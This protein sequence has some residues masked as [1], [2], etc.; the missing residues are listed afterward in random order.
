LSLK[1]IHGSDT[2]TQWKGIPQSV[3]LCILRGNDDY[4]VA[5]VPQELPVRYIR[6]GRLAEEMMYAR[7]DGTIAKLRSKLS[8]L[9][10]L[11]I[12]YLALSPMS[13][14][15]LHDLF[16]VIEDRSSATSTII[17]AQRAPE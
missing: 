11:I 5:A 2:D 14:Q 9:K 8:R 6:S 7:L 13:K 4:G 15:E 16:E 10:L 1:L 12:D 3:Y 17:I